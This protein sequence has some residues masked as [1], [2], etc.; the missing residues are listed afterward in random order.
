[1]NKRFNYSAYTIINEVI[2]NFY[3]KIRFVF[4]NF[5]HHYHSVSEP[6]RDGVISALIEGDAI[7]LKVRNFEPLRYP[8]V[9]VNVEDV[10][11]AHSVS[12]VKLILILRM[13]FAESELSSHTK[14]QIAPSV[15]SIEPL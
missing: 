15:S 4:F 13:K 10:D 5:V 3:H 6:H 7:D 14:L 11:C 12:Y 1:M 9:T 8:Y 2:A